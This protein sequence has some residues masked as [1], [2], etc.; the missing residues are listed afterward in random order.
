MIFTAAAVLAL[1]TGPACGN[2]PVDSD[3]VPH[4]VATAITESGGDSY[5]IGVNADPARGLLAARE[6]AT[7]AG[8]A[9]EKAAALLAQGRRIDLG[10][11]QISDRQLARHHLTLAT[12][13]DECA[14][15]RAGAE[16]L[17]DDYAWTLAHRRYNCGGINCGVAYAQTVTARLGA[18]DS[19]VAPTPSP[20]PPCAPAWDAWALAACSSKPP[21]IHNRLVASQESIQN[22]K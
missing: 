19:V 10:L 1:V 14:N 15:V 17:A 20:P 9:I 13:F 21:G 5:A 7:T 12:A 22:A 4:L 16:H 8:E 2:V 3:L 11:L 18:V 6:T